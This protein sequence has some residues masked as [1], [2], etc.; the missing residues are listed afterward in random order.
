M[1]SERERFEIR[2][3]DLNNKLSYAPGSPED[4]FDMAKDRLYGRAIDA[5]LHSID[6]WRDE[7]DRIAQDIENQVKQGW[8]VIRD[9]PLILQESKD[10]LEAH[11][12]LN[13]A[14]DAYQALLERADSPES[15]EKSNALAE[16]LHASKV[17]QETERNELLEPA[18]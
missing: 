14:K 6:C 1:L 3:V 4:A 5:H 8:A 13:A 16:T 18:F 17:E 11:Q 9:L 12:L 7:R 10:L 15:R 2:I